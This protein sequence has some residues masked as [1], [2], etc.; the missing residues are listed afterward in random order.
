MNLIA[1]LQTIADAYAAKTGITVK[2]A[3][4]Q[5][6]KDQRR[7]D[8]A[9]A[10]QVQLRVDSLEAAFTWFSA[11]WPADLDWPEDIERPEPQLIEAAQ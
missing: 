1:R 11:N 5:I 2:Q 9:F 8:R 10:R 4:Y 7:L 3:S 6:F